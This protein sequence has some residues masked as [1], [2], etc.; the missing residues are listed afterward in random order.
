MALCAFAGRAQWS[1]DSVAVSLVN[2]YPGG[3]IYELEGHTALRLRGPL[4]HDYAVNAG[5][6][7]FSAPNFVYRF[8]KGETDYMVGLQPWDAFV[9]SYARA[10]RRMVEHP[11]N[12]TA[13]QRDRLLEVLD[14]QL[15]PVNRTYRYNYL[16]DNC[17]TRPLGWI[18]EAAGD[19][20][21]FPAA[22]ENTGR[23]F[24][25]IMTWYHRNYPWYQF[26]IDLA[27]GSGIDIPVN[28]RMRAFAP[29]EL[30]AMLPGVT[31]GDGTPLTSGAVTIIDTPADN[32]VAGHTPWPL[33]PMTVCWAV[34]I[35]VLAVS[36]RDWRRG[37][38]TRWVD[39]VLM[40]VF[41]LA[42]CVL[43]FLVLISVHEA[44]SPNFLL[45]W[46]NPLCWIAAI[47]VWLKKW[48]GLVETYQICNFVLLT[49]MLLTWWACPQSVNPA[50]LPLVLADMCRA[51]VTVR[52][53]RKSYTE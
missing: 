10:G 20:L 41:G 14:R 31:L 6:F 28:A 40:G 23:T 11:L 43:L 53:Y 27:L 24:R 4:G 46:L 15:Q 51:A 48:K 45:V 3:E 21:S 13:A 44:T 36:M 35:A 49:L 9:A 38:L 32:A 52:I 33:H 26:G 25:D 8:V 37:R 18:E 50:I 29:V 22:D 19:S 42:G 1:P 30:E 16:Y 39:S 47:G 34:F 12:L 17:A 5:L 2:V 7:D